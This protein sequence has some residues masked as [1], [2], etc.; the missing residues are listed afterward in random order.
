M[1]QQRLESLVINV[2]VFVGLA[3]LF[4]GLWMLRPWLAMTVVGFLFFGAGVRT[5][6]RK[7]PR[8]SRE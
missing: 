6:N 3:M 5:L 1:T 8:E 2:A 7:P 4:A